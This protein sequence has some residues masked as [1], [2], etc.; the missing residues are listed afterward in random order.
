MRTRTFD[1]LPSSRIDR[2][3]GVVFE[4]QG[5][6]DTQDA[7][8]G[9]QNVGRFQRARWDARPSKWS[10]PTTWPSFQTATGHQH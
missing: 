6:I 5:L 4:R 9:G 1:G 3:A 7:V 2:A 8:R 10:L